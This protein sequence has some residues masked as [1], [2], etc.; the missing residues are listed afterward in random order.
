MGFIKNLKLVFTYG[1]EIEAIL[2]KLKDDKRKQ[3][4][5]DDKHRLNLCFAHRQEKHQSHYAEHNCDYC[6]AIN[7]LPTKWKY[8]TTR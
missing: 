4:W 3:Q 5:E 6:K 1:D 8:S 7:E 2:K